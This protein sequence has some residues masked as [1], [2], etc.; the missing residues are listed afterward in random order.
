MIRTSILAA[1]SLLAASPSLPQP[2]ASAPAAPARSYRAIDTVSWSYGLESFPGGS[3]P[4]LRFKH[5][6]SNSSIDTDHDPE[7]MRIVD[8]IAH[9]SA[10]QPLSFNIARE[11]GTLACTGRADAA[12]RGSGTCRFDPDARF[13]G[14]LA[15]RGLAPDDSDDLLALTLVDAHLATVD[16]L[17]SAG[18]RLDKAGDLIAVS[19]LGVTPAYAGGLRGAGLKIDE[20]GDLIAAKA[21][22]IDGQWLGEMARAGYPDLAVGQAIQ[23]RA[24]GV[25]PDY[26]MRM[27]RVLH[28]VGE[29]Q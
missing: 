8:T 5:D 14:E 24:L 21:L 26:A 29:I 10:G 2:A 18:F 4:Q 11:A 27:Q 9:A 17:A 12:G 22:K 28:A 25:T 19:A 3:A 13:A 16:G 15:Q 1:L 7:V 20:L 23:M 6:H